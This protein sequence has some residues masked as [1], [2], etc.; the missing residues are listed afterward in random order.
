MWLQNERVLSDVI[1]LVSFSRLFAS[2]CAREISMH[3]KQVAYGWMCG[4]WVLL[5]REDRLIYVHKVNKKRK[6]PDISLAHFKEV[7]NRDD[8]LD[9]RMDKK[10]I[11]FAPKEILNMKATTHIISPLTMQNC[12]TRISMN[13]DTIRNYWSVSVQEPTKIFY[14]KRH[15]HK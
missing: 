3:V 11:N 5:H 2:K 13:F 15:R 1:T 10:E 9:K 12:S 4:W 8:S 14:T 6:Q 7:N